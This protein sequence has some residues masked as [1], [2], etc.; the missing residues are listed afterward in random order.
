MD[1]VGGAW[2]SSLMSFTTWGKPVVTT[3]VMGGWKVLQ[4]LSSGQHS[5]TFTHTYRPQKSAQPSPRPTR[6]GNVSCRQQEEHHKGHGC[7]EGQRVV[8]NHSIYLEVISWRECGV[9]LLREGADARQVSEGLQWD[10]GATSNLSGTS[11]VWVDLSWLCGYDQKFWV[12]SENRVSSPY[13]CLWRT[14]TQAGRWAVVPELHFPPLEMGRKSLF[15]C[16]SHLL[17]QETE[18]RVCNWLLEMHSCPLGDRSIQLSPRLLL[19]FILSL[20]C[21]KVLKW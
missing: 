16:P 21:K 17:L 18:S 10:G 7:R 2:Q 4:N 20:I 11:A 12:I 15:F 8:A 6:L 9:M 5:A 14:A 1:R 13:T 19:V 3:W